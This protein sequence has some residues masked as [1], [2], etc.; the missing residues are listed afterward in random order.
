MRKKFAYVKNE[1]DIC[2]E[3]Y[4]RIWKWTTKMKD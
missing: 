3:K 2:G 4:E 1:S